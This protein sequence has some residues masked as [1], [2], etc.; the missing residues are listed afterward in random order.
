MNANIV[1]APLNGSNALYNTVGI[2][3]FL[4]TDLA[5]TGESLG[6]GQ[7]VQWID[8]DGDEAD[9]DADAAEEMLR[10]AG[11]CVVGGWDKP[12]ADYFQ[13]RIESID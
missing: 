8:F 1:F 13:A 4:D 5:E 7:H 2:D 6:D 11:Y 3:L 9:F 10:V 12:C